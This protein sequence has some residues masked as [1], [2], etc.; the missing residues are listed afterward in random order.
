LCRA[1]ERDGR[2]LR[3]VAADDPEV[4]RWLSPAGIERALAPENFLGGAGTFV[5]RV[6][7]Q[8]AM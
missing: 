7:Q 2:P 8:W 1:A 6:L 5:D 4:S 3:E